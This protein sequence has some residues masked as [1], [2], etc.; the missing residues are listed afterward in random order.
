MALGK[1]LNRLT[2]LGFG[3]PVCEKEG[4]RG[5]WLAGAAVSERV[6]RSPLSG[7]QSS[8]HQCRHP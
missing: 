2:G 7:P 8:R 1:S 4:N 6:L 5:I 3:F